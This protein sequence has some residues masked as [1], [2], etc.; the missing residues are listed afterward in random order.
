MIHRSDRLIP[1][2]QPQRRPH[3]CHSSILLLPVI[4]FVI[5]FIVF[6]RG[7]KVKHTYSTAL[8]DGLIR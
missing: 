6:Q 7:T 5:L 1:R 4:V 2:R 8:F 3:Y